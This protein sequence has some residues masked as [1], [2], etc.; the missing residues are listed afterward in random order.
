VEESESRDVTTPAAVSTVQPEGQSPTP[1]QPAAPSFVFAI[2][3]VAPR[4]P[5]VSVEREFAQ[6]MGR[7]DT[8][9]L[10]DRQALH[11]ILAERA[12]R[13]LARQLCWTFIIEGLETYVLVPRDSADYDL[14]I[15]AVRADPDRNDI[16]VVIGYLGPIAPPEVCNGLTVP[17]VIFDQLYSFDRD[18]LLDAI[19][20]EEGEGE[21]DAEQFRS[22]AAELFD[23]IMQLAD[24][25]GATDEHRAL[26]YLAARYHA[27]YV[28]TARAHQRNASLTAVDVRPSRLAGVRNIVDV[29]FSYTDRATDVT[30]KYFVRVDV[31]DMF[32]FLVTKLSP[33][34]DR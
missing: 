3:R 11:R 31:T 15:E 26:N 7:G 2:G 30:D 18:S 29:V 12:N 28:E 32:P 19:P 4:F 21:P 20:H 22:T 34:Y 8:D 27:I 1:A 13:Y 5:T 17:V 14:L 24:N 23:R 10:T 16:D 6:A 9:G 33:F 25:A